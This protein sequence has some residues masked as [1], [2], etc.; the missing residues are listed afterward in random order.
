MHRLLKTS[1]SGYL[2]TGKYACPLENC[3]HQ[4]I[5]FV[6]WVTLLVDLV[7]QIQN[8]TADGGAMPIEA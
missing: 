4:T 7:V 2:A 8:E 1:I 5:S 6:L 3:H